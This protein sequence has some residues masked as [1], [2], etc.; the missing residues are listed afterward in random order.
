VN[1]HTVIIPE[2]HKEL[3]KGNVKLKPQII[4]YVVDENAGHKRK[5]NRH[6]K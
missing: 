4:R 3:I 6:V 1:N 2:M 5:S